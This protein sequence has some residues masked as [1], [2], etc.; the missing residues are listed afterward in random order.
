MTDYTPGSAYQKGFNTRMSGGDKASNVYESNSVYWQ[1]WVAGWDDAHN[2]II[3]ES[4]AK[5]CEQ[6]KKCCKTKKF[7]QD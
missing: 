3:N 1:E 2:K 7:I 4:R 5:N 6:P